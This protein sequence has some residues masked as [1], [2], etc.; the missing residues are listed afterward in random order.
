MT[1]QDRIRNFCII[2][3]IDHGKSTLADRLLEMTGTVNKRNMQAQLLDSMDIERERGITIKLAPVRMNYVKDGKEYTLNLIDTP[4]HVDFSYEVS[5]SL[6]AVEGAILLVDATQGVQAQTIGNLYLALEQDLEII[7]V[8][9]KIDLPAAD[10]PTRTAEIIK[11]IGCKEEDILAVSGKTG[12]GVQ[13][14]L[15]AVIDRVAP[16][17]GSQ[18]DSPRALVFDSYY[19]DYRGVVAYVRVFDGELRKR[20][21][22]KMIASKADAEILDVGKLAPRFSAIES[23]ETGQIGAVVTGFKDISACRVGDTM[24]V[25]SAKLAEPLAGYKEVKPMV[26]AG[27]FPEEGDDYPA[28]RDAVDRL[29]L[30]DASLVFD[31][32][33][34]PALGYGFRVG[35]LGMLHLEILKERLER[36][37][38]LNLIVTVPSVAYHVYKKLVP[39]PVVIKSPH[40]LPDGSFIDRIEEPWAKVDIIT[41]TDYIGSIMNF[42]QDR[43]AR[44]V[45]TE[46]LSET[47]AI[48]KYEMPL[49]QVIV[50]FYD[51]LKSVSSGF[52]SMNY[53]V[54]NYQPADV[55]R[56][57][58]LVAEDPVEALATFCYRADA[59]KVGK[60][61]VETLKDQIPKQQFVIKLQAAI[62]GKIVAGD[63]ISAVR[64][65]V[66]AG[67]YGGDVSRK[68]KVL[69]KQ[70]KGKKKMM[71]M[72]K[73]KVN[74]PG[75]VY[76]NV[77]RR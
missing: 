77:L 70:K 50:D 55:V 14:V 57:D 36:E 43:N 5:R 64:K 23:L 2:A 66:T 49:S 7:P 6:A 39:E 24:T 17:Q 18:A 44:Y 32:E 4:G 47:R 9:N 53:E 8:L 59:G 35:L 75:E 72:G 29:T 41:P 19:D 69:E 52:A 46:F 12:E 51:K 25:L 58:I 22:L 45:T 16:P 26:F 20:D 10:L 71:A 74:I 3:H 60:R 37:F 54:F 13:G 11:L 21:R 65:D 1:P 67:L 42:V 15:D 31:P 27:I 63:K 28:L 48:L 62:G 33:H 56:L 30:N 38:G 61:I 73:G 40:D 76:L 34:S 68:K